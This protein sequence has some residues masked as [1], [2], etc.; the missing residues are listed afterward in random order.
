MTGVS[1]LSEG[2]AAPGSRRTSP[3]PMD[4]MAAT[5][6][7]AKKASAHGGRRSSPHPRAAGSSAPSTTEG[8]SASGTRK[9]SPRPREGSNPATGSAAAVGEAKAQQAE[10]TTWIQCD[11]PKAVKPS[12]VPDGEWFCANSKDPLRRSCSVPQELPDEQ[13]DHLLEMEA[14]AKFVAR[15]KRPDIEVCT[16]AQFEEDLIKYLEHRNEG[17]LAKQIKEKRVMCNTTPLDML[18]L[19]RAVVDVGGLEANE[20]YDENGRWTGRINFSGSVFRKMTN[21]TENNKATS[22]GNQLLTNYKKFLLSYERANASRDIKVTPEPLLGISNNGRAGRPKGPSAPD[23][24]L[25]PPRDRRPRQPDQP[26]APDPLVYLATVAAV[27]STGDCLRGGRASKAAP[28]D[29]GQPAGQRVRVKPP[30]LDTANMVLDPQRST[31]GCTEDMVAIQKEVDKQASFMWVSMSNEIPPSTPVWTPRSHSPPL[32]GELLLVRD[33]YVESRLWPIVVA[34]LPDVP[35]IVADGESCCGMENASTSGRALDVLS[36]HKVAS[37]GGSKGSPVFPALLLG[38]S[39]LGWV[40]AS[41]CQMYSQAD[42]ERAAAV[43]MPQLL[44]ELRVEGR[45]VVDTTGRRN[46]L[47]GAIK[48]AAALHHS[49]HK[50]EHAR[51]LVQAASIQICAARLMALEADLPASAFWCRSSAMWQ[52]FRLSVQEA[53]TPGHLVPQTLF[54]AHQLIPAALKSHA[55]KPMWARVQRLL[56]VNGPGG[57]P[58]EDSAGSHPMGSSPSCCAVDDV[59]SAIETAINWETIA[60]MWEQTVTNST[61]TTDGDAVVVRTAVHA[62]EALGSAPLPSASE[63]VGAAAEAPQTKSAGALRGPVREPS[64]RTVRSTYRRSPEE[65]AVGKKLKSR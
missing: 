39:T 1:T 46:I 42:T 34:S 49:L 55:Y 2:K 14:N 51:A 64:K 12:Q 62:A 15:S 61:V 45:H 43:W 44:R 18:G 52:T 50:R 54:L 40:N 25:R 38:S 9:S 30:A 24:K 7:A 13:I 59:V 11:N 53:S 19:Y 60:S 26:M 35:R 23:L 8:K 6:R 17:P 48:E 58:P 36:S 65:G 41:R 16:T 33:Q 32:P 63:E 5:N 31:K 28:D 47:A 29:S 20:S 27:P 21:F 3:R 4:E 22:I 57:L 10:P 37:E 56:M